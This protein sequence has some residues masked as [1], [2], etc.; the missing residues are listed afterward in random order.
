MKPFLTAAITFFILISSSAAALAAQHPAASLDFSTLDGYILGQME[1]HA[2][3]GVSLAVVQGAETV[4]LKGYG[5]AGSLPVTPQTKMLIGS[6]SKSFTAL[7]IAQLSEAGK[8]DLDAPV[9]AYIPWFQVADEEA[10]A[11][12]TVNHLLHHTSGLSESGFSVVIP[13]EATPEESVRLLAKAYPTAP[14][15]KKF[16]YFNNNYSV[17]AYLIETV[18]GQSYASYMQEHIFAPLGMTS[19]SAD[20]AAASSLG[21]SYTRLFG[22]PA[23]M[24]QPIQVF[25]MGAG[26]I[27]STAEDMARYAAAMK[28]NGELGQARLI[29]PETVQLLF[30]PWLDGYAMGW[31]IDQTG[32]KIYHGGA[33]ETFGAVVNLYPEQDTA[34]VL[35]V[36][37]GHLIDHYI[38]IVQLTAGVEA[39]LLE[40]AVPPVSQGISVKMVGWGIGALVLALFG[41]SVWNF[42]QLF[43]GW[44]DRMR[45]LSPFK[46]GFDVALSFIIPTAILLIVLSQVRAFF[47]YRFNLVTTVTQFPSSLPDIFL[48]MLVSTLF[49]YIQGII[50]IVWIVMGKTKAKP[51]TKPA[52][53]TGRISV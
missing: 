12:I 47:G 33:N 21:R 44:V 43:N 38:S 48:L 23:P 14:V 8:I 37:E 17:L 46:K 7:A 18:S 3:P 1:K 35:L 36:N 53:S 49:D 28:N 2:L 4:Y 52:C 15:G 32:Q 31:N 42:R 13:D 6:Q 45:L 20:P 29:S 39:I 16:Q 25:A 5:K 9:Q 26:Y 50:K 24:E 41:L 22:F 10:S 27:V 30:T 51:V 11:K 19:T 34:F 40:K